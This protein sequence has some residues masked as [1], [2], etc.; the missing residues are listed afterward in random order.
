MRS[1]LPGVSA[2][3]TQLQPTLRLVLPNRHPF[4]SFPE[5]GGREVDTWTFRRCEVLFKELGCACVLLT[6]Y[7]MP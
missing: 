2:F 6:P 1:S 7:V 4:I 5:N 3:S